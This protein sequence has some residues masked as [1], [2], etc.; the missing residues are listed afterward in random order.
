M[1]ENARRGRQD[2][3]YELLDTGILDDDRF[4]DITADY[5]QAA[6]GDW[7]IRLRARNAGPEQATL[8]VLPHGVVPQHVVVGARSTAA[9]ASST[10]AVRWWPITTRSVA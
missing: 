9:R 5:A 10:T 8:D 2:P 1:A 7:C 3:E 6:P 4:W